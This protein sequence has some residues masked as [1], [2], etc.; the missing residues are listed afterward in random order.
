MWARLRGH[1]AQARR[2]AEQLRH[3]TE[4]RSAERDKLEHRIDLLATEPRIVA[5]PLDEARLRVEDELESI[6]DQQRALRGRLHQLL[7]IGPA[8][9]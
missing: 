1:A 5:P 7:L 4:V 2:R 6:R 9:N 8:A 3:D